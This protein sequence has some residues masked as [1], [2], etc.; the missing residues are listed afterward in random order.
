MNAPETIRQIIEVN[1]GKLIGKTRLQKTAYFLESLGLGF[2]FNFD[3]HYYGPYSDDL[4]TATEDAEALG[5]IAVDW[6]IS[7]AGMPYAVFSVSSPT[8]GPEHGRET[9]QRNL[10]SVLDRYDATSL[11]LAATADFL[12]RNGFGADPWAETKRRKSLKA[13][14]ERVAKAKRLLEEV[15]A[16]RNE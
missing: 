13:T 5:V 3:Y 14:E 2:G 6:Q 1:G 7:Q 4:A 9:K 15:E 10:L 16:V 12:A 8:S 11:E